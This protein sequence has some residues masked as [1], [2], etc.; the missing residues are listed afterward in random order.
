MV[1]TI[2]AGL[3]LRGLQAAYT[4]DPGFAYR[5]VAYVSLE[6]AF[7]GYTPD[8]SEARRHQLLAALAALPNVEAVASAE[9]EPLGDD[10][11]PALIRIPGE[12]EGQSRV[13]EVVPVSES[14]FSVL[15]LPILRGRAFTDGE[16]RN[17]AASPRPAILSATTAR[18]LWPGGD[19]IGRTLLWQRPAIDAVD[20]L[21]VVGVAADAQVTALGQIDPYYVYVPGEGGALLVKGRSDVATT[22]A[23]IRAA[24]RAVDPA[25]LVTVLPLEATLAWSR[26]ISG[27]VTTL[28][29]G[30]GVLA[31]VLAAV[32]IYGVVA[33][34]VA[35]RYRE[36]GVRLAL[37]ATAN[38]VLGLVLR[39]TM[40]PVVVGAVIGI[41]GASAMS[42]VLS[43]VLYGVSPADP[44]GLGGAALVVL[45]VALAA[46]VAAARPATRADPKTM[47][48]YE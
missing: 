33:F 39:Q 10:T 16:V 28:F 17:Q 7:D 27:T 32:G 31:L 11:A 18:N 1:L 25:L 48:R 23:G 12:S 6:S 3:V 15:E 22:V 24:V 20:T 35:G 13:G 38:G 47:L 36:I 21:Q 46:G 19:P 42:S 26:G 44:L 5:N 30:L 9:Q 2:A 37:G 29:G 41:V 45:I 14:Y 43:G 34:A 8:E 4:I 40:R